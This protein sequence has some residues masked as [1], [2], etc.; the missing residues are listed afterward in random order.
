MR[1]ILVSLLTLGAV[2][3]T[4]VAATGAYFSDT[5]TS[6]GNTFVAGTLT[7]DV[8]NNGS[9]GTFPINLGT[10]TGF[11][12][13][14][15]TQEVSLVIKNTGT[16]NYAWFGYFD[17]TGITQD[18]DKAIYIKSAKMEFLY[19][20]LITTWEP[21]D[22]FITNGTGSGPYPAWYTALAASDPFG[23]I[24]M[25]TFNG[26]NNMMGA[27]NGVF[28]GALKPNYSYKLTFR[29]AMVPEAGNEYQAGTMTVA[30]KILATQ[31]NAAAIDA[32]S[33]GDTRIDAVGAD[34]MTWLNQQIAK[35]P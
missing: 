20:D 21:A 33:A 17:L 4:V 14:D 2:A 10:L 7:V 22:Q 29:L 19:P 12:P 31:I 18:M 6:E 30:Y 35:Q 16:M 9:T 8:N 27:G 24:S 3:A 25:R 11:A 5:E 26:S 34:H 28:M 32:L 15:E 13:G 1:K 23:V